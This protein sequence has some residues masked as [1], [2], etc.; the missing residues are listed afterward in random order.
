MKVDMSEKE[1]KPL[2][3]EELAELIK[4]VIENPEKY[5]IW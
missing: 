4:K 1:I 3:K 2:S 5:P